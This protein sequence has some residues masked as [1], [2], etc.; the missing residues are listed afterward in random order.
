[1]CPACRTRITSSG[2]QDLLLQSQPAPQRGEESD[3]EDGASE[4]EVSEIVSK[5]SPRNMITV[6]CSGLVIVTVGLFCSF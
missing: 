6:V 1:M 5:S 4:E 2:S 3:L